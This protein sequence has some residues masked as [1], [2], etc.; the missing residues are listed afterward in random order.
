MAIVKRAHHMS[1]QIR[2]LEKSRAFYEGI[3]GFEQ[4][5]RPDFGFPG[6]WYQ[7]GDMQVHLIG[8]IP[9]M[10]RATPPR[11]LSPAATHL[12]FQIDD[13]EKVLAAL[14]KEG[15]EVMGLGGEVGQ[16][17]VQD[18]DGNVIELIVP[19]GRLGRRKTA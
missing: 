13:Y 8:E 4:T 15:L 7:I 11:G 12:A 18:P 19:G 5:E 14:Q 6:V 9:G 1:V 16:I 17:F 3:L 2:D 10:E